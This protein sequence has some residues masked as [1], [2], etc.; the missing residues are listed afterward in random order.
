ME[1]NK[2]IPFYFRQPTLESVSIIDLHKAIDRYPYCASLHYLLLKKQ[3]TEQDPDFK[4]QLNRA[5]LFF[6]NA[7]HLQAMLQETSVFAKPLANRDRQE[8]VK[9]ADPEPVADPVQAP[10]EIAV[11][12][13]LPIAA[14]EAAPQP[15]VFF[16]EN[17]AESREKEPETPE[18]PI[19]AGPEPGETIVPVIPES[20]PEPALRTDL[21]RME[22]PIPIP[23]L[24]DIGPQNDDLPVFEPYHTIDYFASQGIKLSQE[25]PSNDRLGRQMRSFTDW[26][27]TM[28]KLPQAEL[29]DKLDEADMGE[30]IVAMAAGSVIARE[31][32]TETMAEVLVKQGNFGGAVDLYRK[33]SLAHPDKSAYFAARIEHLNKQ[34]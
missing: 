17:L 21:L 18:T 29:Q 27:R 6:P 16:V 24:K 2:T 10:A 11:A 33:L 4:K 12:E 20:R 32:V 34:K 28:K 13:T 1:L 15:T 9:L 23:S 3:L 5:Y 19:A 14:P 31:V 8:Q 25:L 26:I 7:F 30:K 22:S